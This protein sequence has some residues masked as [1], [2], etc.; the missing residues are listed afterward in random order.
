MALTGTDAATAPGTA[1]PGPLRRFGALPGLLCRTLFA[2]VRIDAGAIE[3]VRELAA[4][5]SI[6]YVM[7]YRSLVDYMLV[8]FVLLREGLPLPEFVTDVPTAL[9]RP[10]R[11]IA[12]AL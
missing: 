9:L 10:A 8:A 2:Q 7:R 6:V 12:G 3:H 5:G 1:N 11:E 4:R